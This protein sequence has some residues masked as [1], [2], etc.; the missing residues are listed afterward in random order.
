M[1][2]GRY[3][4]NTNTND[5]NRKNVDSDL[6]NNCLIQLKSNKAKNKIIW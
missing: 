6:H 4:C 2:V 3:I 1:Q 5:N